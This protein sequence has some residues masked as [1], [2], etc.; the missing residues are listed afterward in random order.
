MTIGKGAGKGLSSPQVLR[1]LKQWCVDG[2]LGTSRMDHML[3]NR[4]PIDTEEIL[5]GGLLDS[6][7]VFYF[8]AQP[9]AAEL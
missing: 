5:S 6:A 3:L 2:V 9:R 8:D 7:R 1:R 4:R